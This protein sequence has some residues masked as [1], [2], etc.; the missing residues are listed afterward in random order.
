ML[1][2]DDDPDTLES[3]RSLLENSPD[4]PR[5]LTA[6]SPS[7]ALHILSVESVDLVVADYLMKPVNGLDFLTDARQRA[8]ETARVLI[9]GHP[10]VQVVIDAINQ[11]GVDHFFLKPI[12][13][14][15][16]VAAVQRTRSRHPARSGLRHSERWSASTPP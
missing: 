3:L 7:E 4:P 14:E 11:A 1:L 15:R 5:V 16:F 2:V 10:N 12:P 6:E 9:T 13:P 8:P